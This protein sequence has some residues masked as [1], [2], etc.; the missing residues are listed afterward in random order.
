M[1]KAA[2]LLCLAGSF[3]PLFSAPCTTGTI[4]DYSANFGSAATDCSNGILLYN[5]FSSTGIP[6]GATFTLTPNT[7][8]GFNFSL[9]A[10]GTTIPYLAITNTS[11]SIIYEFTIDPAPILGG[12]SLRLD[13]PT[14]SDVISQI[15]C[16]DSNPTAGFAG[17]LAN[18]G[19]VATQTI[20]VTNANPDAS[21]TFNP[22]ALSFGWVETTFS[23]DPVNGIPASFDSTDSLPDVEL[24]GSPEPVS[25]ALMGFGLVALGGA[26]LI[27]RRR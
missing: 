25:L 18:A 17:C 9:T 2:L 5:N 12:S 16:L 22:P 15:F 4:Q 27:R 8:E 7:S 10:T 26:K 3:V 14:G 21:I 24:V 13:P 19:P 11:F 6:S 23:M 1:F 20:T